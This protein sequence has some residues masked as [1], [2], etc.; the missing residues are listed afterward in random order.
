MRFFKGNFSSDY[1]KKNNLKDFHS[2]QDDFIE[3]VH[4]SACVTMKM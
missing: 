1:S 3:L 4:I 2:V